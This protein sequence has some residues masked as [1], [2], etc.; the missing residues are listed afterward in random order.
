[1]TDAPPIAFESPLVAVLVIGLGLAFVFGTIANRLNLSPIVG[2]L[3]AGVAV[4]PFTPGFVAD[5]KLT[6][7]LAEVGVILLMFGVGLHFSPKDLLAVRRIAIP[8]ALLQVTFA[9]ALGAGA[10]W[11]IGWPLGTGI[12]FG[13]ALSVASTVVMTRTLQDRHLTESTRGHIAIGWL[14]MQDLITVLALVLLPPLAGALLQVTFATAL[15]AGAAWLIG[16]PLGTG[17]VFGLALS[18]ASTVVMTRTLQDRHLT[19]STRGHIAIGWLVMQDLITV[20]ALVLLPPL[21]SALKGG[22]IDAGALA[23]SLLFTFAKL[24]AF[25]ALML[26]VGRRVIP[27]ILHYTAHTGSRELFRLAVLSVALGVAFLAAELFGVSIALGAFFAGMILSGSQLSQRAAEESLPLRDAFA[28]LFF[29]SVGVIFNPMVI[30]EEP[31]SLVLSL[32][33]VMV[34]TGGI[35]FVISRL[36]GYP[37]STALFI[38]AGLAQIGEFS[39]ILADLGIDQG[40]LPDRARDLILGTSILSILANPFLVAAAERFRKPEA[41]APEAVREKPAELSPTRL[42][43]H[44][45]VVGYGRVG[46]LV[47]AGLKSD[48]TPLLVIEEAQD[49]IETLERE[50]IEAIEGNAAMDR[51]LKAANVAGARLLFIAI[52]EAFEAGQIVQQARAANPALEIVARAH[53]DAEVDHLLKLGASEV[54]M[55][56]REIAHAM[57][58]HARAVA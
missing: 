23:T 46:S 47:G 34:G 6:L 8:G 21:A 48:G 41:A 39:F 9:T 54:I 11:L 19:E 2:Y 26:I 27:A 28:V 33:V 4:G 58:D 55:G 13:L 43:D 25:V 56:E 10:A 50:G 1:M 35:A 49:R 57:L 42:T 24:G 3:V 37:L 12:V 31:G 44:A 15:G 45:I 36:F 18:V 14:V 40:L 29:V 20:L 30:V 16:W 38:G 32:L 5:T 22:S 17:I 51:V 52:P 53:F 7:Q